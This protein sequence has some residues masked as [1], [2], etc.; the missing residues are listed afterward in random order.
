MA[1]RL[2]TADGRYTH[3]EV[4][5]KLLDPAGLVGQRFEVRDPGGSTRFELTDVFDAT[6]SLNSDQ[7]IKGACQMVLAADDRLLGRPFFFRIACFLQVGPMHDGGTAELP[8]GVYVFPDA[9]RTIYVGP[10]GVEHDERFA[11]TMADQQLLLESFPLDGLTGERGE[12]VTDVI[13]RALLAAGVTDTSGVVPSDETLDEGLRWT[14]K[15]GAQKRRRVPRRRYERS[16]R[17]Y[18]RMVSQGRARR[19]P[20]RYVWKDRQETPETL[21]AIVDD[22]ADSVGYDP[23]FFDLTGR[24]KLGPARDVSVESPDFTY[25]AGQN[26]VILE[27]IQV[28]PNMEEL[29]NYVIARTTTAG[30]KQR[31]ATADLNDILPDHPLA[32]HHHGFYFPVP[33]DETRATSVEALEQRARRHL[34]EQA[35]YY[36]TARLV[37]AAM[38]LHETPDIYGLVLPGVDGFEDGTGAWQG[39]GWSMNL[40][41][42]AMEHDIRQAFREV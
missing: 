41:G 34:L 21:N 33:L 24:Y 12:P 22:L 15:R 35:N 2:D 18:H 4:V 37:T 42:E 16:L 3:E 26:G 38:P 9:E 23:G 5:A 31:I 36:R 8:A 17:R 39:I 13:V 32:E 20:R 25:A 30:G 28:T 11:V 10:D 19:R 14:V 7:E 1:R 29:A 40:F 6:V 27:D